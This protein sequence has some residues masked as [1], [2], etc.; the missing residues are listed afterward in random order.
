M[1][2]LVN[3]LAG[4]GDTLIATPFLHELRANFPEAI[5]DVFVLWAGSRDILEGNPNIN[6]VY[7]KNLI[8]AGAFRSLPF[9]L[10]LRRRRYDVSIN[11]H[12]LGRIHYRAMARF[13]GAPLRLSHAYHGSN[14]RLDRLLV[15]RTLPEDYSVH[16]V[17]NNN[18]LLALLDRQP[19]L[20]RHEFEIF[21]TDAETKWAAQ[22][23]EM[24]APAPRR[25]LGIHIG[26]GG[27][28]NLRL[29]RWPF[30]HYRELLARLRKSHPE[31][32]VLLFGGPEEQREHTQ[33]LAECEDVFAPPTKNLRQA[34]ALLK[35]CDAFL[36]VD[37]SLMHLAAA[38]KVPHQIV[39]EAPTLN[40]T[41]LPWL[42][43][44]Q[45]VRN[46]V[47]NGRNL[48]YY[49]YDGKPI[50]GSD[51]ELIAMMSSVTV[52]AVH[53]AVADALH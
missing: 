8:Q 4:I 23:I 3:S 42:N 40:A 26:S 45:L 33:I 25:R 35:H 6:A 31:T 39:I 12:T 37:T 17:E 19:M 29:K 14:K 27:T 43:P 49:R 13:I 18:R 11:V 10:D 7:Q 32:V 21:L 44:Y 53:S 50:K 34:A 9:L 24:H 52:D 15:N 38:I 22:I 16:S 5:I 51:E 20:P 47:L 1:K 46:P 28:K 30:A 36:S 2:I 41:N 48:D